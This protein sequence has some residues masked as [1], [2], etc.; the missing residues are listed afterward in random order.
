MKTIKLFYASIFIGFLLMAANTVVITQFLADIPDP[1]KNEIKLTW[2][3]QD[4]VNL[5]HY[6]IRRKMVR[7]QE[8][9][10]IATV[11]PQ[12]PSATPNSYE[13]T[14]RNVFRN[15][16]N[17]EPVTYELNAVFTNGDRSFVGQ[18]EVNYTS[19]A[20]RRTWGSIKAMFQ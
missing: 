18:A 16:E 2:V 20:V 3:A 19:T 4:E 8:F 13:Y 6:E 11:A 12:P 17:S 9:Y 10:T 1:N 15:N 7:D 5:Q 14:D